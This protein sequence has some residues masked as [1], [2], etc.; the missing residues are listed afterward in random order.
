MIAKA[1]GKRLAANAVVEIRI[2]DALE[3]PGRWLKLVEALC[4]APLMVADVTGFEPGIMLALGVRAVVRR[5][6]TVAS[7]GGDLNDATLATLPFNIQE[8]KLISHGKSV[9]DPVSRE[10]ASPAEHDR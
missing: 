7:T 9:E 2:A 6:V 3:T 8:T 4:V 1:T 10:L 5:G